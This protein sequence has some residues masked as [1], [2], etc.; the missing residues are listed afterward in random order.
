VAEKAGG[1]Q[2]RCAPPR[3]PI[4]RR[5]FVQQQ[6]RRFDVAHLAG[7]V[8]RRLTVLHRPVDHRAFVQQQSC[9][10]DVALLAGDDQRRP[11]V[12]VRPI[13]LGAAVDEP[14]HRVDVAGLGRCVQPVNMLLEQRNDGRVAFLLRD[15]QRRRTVLRSPV[16]RRAFF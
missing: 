12:L 3:R 13:D 6:P 8:Q 1:E 7:D 16:D 9:R 2:R 4:N 15:A 10:G 5:A 14:R 11:T